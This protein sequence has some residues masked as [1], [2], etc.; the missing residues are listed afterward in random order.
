MLVMGLDTS[1][2]RC[3]VAILKNGDVLADQSLDMEK[4]HAEHLA[5]LAAA[6][7][8]AAKIS[9]GDLDRVGV[10][11]GPGGFSG[12]RVGLSFARGLAIGADFDVV[13]VTTLAALARNLKG[14]A[15]S[16]LIAPLIDARRGQ[17]YAG[18][19]END[20]AVLVDPFVATPDEVFAK[21]K[22]AARDRPVSLIGTGAAHMAEGEPQ[23]SKPLIPM[24]IDARNVALLAAE[25]PPSAAPPAPLYLRAPDAKPPK[26][27]RFDG[28]STP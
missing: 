20:G 13:G 7:L 19:Y 12:I 3:S 8:K 16:A 22:S 10:V 9:I 6:A 2:Q 27:S 28:L 11:I 14:V 18:L 17:L 5:P 21:L 25:A 1:L 26:S 4:G 24:Q 15:P 23:F